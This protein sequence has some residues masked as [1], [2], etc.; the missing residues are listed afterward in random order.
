MAGLYLRVFG[1]TAAKVLKRVDEGKQGL[2]L[3]LWKSRVGV[4]CGLGFAAMP[5]DRFFD[6]ACSPVMQKI[7]VFAD[8]GCEPYPP[9]WRGPPF[10]PTGLTFWSVIGKAFA[11]VVQQEIRVRPDALV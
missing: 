3:R 10:T 1:G 7:S 9:E 8:G 11:H 6:S 5:E 2:P 4:A